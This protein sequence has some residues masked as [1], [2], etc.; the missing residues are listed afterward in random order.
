MLFLY[1]L[2]PILL[3]SCSLLADAILNVSNLGGLV[4]GDVDRHAVWKSCC[5]HFLSPW[6]VSG[7]TFEVIITLVMCSP[8]AIDGVCVS[9]CQS[10]LSS[11]YLQR[12]EF[13]LICQYILR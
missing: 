4:I 13:F 7:A 9:V 6:Y 1:V 2:V 8:S 3:M 5:F 11:F 12:Y 10:A